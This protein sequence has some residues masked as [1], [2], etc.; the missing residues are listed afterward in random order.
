M[1]PPWC[2]KGD[3]VSFSR[4]LDPGILAPPLRA[5]RSSPGGRDGT[6]RL[7]GGTVEGA[8]TG[9][10]EAVSPRPVTWGTEHL[11]L[12]ARVAKMSGALLQRPFRRAATR[13]SSQQAVPGTLGHRASRGRTQRESDSWS[14]VRSERRTARLWRVSRPLPS[15]NATSAAVPSSRPG[16]D[17]ASRGAGV[18]FPGSTRRERADRSHFSAERDRASSGATPRDPSHRGRCSTP[19]AAPGH[20]RCPPSP[21]ELRRSSSPSGR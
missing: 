13:A 16:R 2:L 11:F 3:Q 6:G 21:S 8:P 5:S 17:R 12:G 1:G 4:C 7:H 19:E 20:A 15:L 9:A 18:L 14:P 10:A